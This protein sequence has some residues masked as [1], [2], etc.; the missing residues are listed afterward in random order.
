MRRILDRKNVRKIIYILFAAIL[1]AWGLQHIPYFYGMLMSLLKPMVPLIIGG[2]LAFILNIPMRFLEEKVITIKKEKR[3]R[4][5]SF[6]LT[7]LLVF[8]IFGLILF[9]VIPEL[10]RTFENIATMIPAFIKEATGWFDGFMTRFPMFADYIN[11]IDMSFDELGN[12]LLDLIKNSGDDVADFT[13]RLLSSLFGGALNVFLGFIF[14][15]YILFDKENLGRQVRRLLYAYLPEK[16][17]DQFIGVLGIINRIFHSFVTGQLTEAVILGSMFV[18]TM[19]IF[20][21]P[22]AVLV[23]ILVAVTAIIPVVG[24]FIAMFIGGFLIFVVNPM[25]AVW[26]VLLFLVLQQIEGNLIY[27]K[28]VGSSIGLPGIWVLAAV[29]VGGGLYGVLGVL[30]AVP[31]SSVVYTLLKR[32]VAHQ[33]KDEKPVDKR[34]YQ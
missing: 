23:G 1:F 24:A 3:R 25:Q 21:F 6:L 28:V 12:S 10:A 30:L 14:A 7:I 5:V 29:M 22:Y 2:A 16:K 19:F 32:D 33:L 11:G 27:P 18:V 34:K 26:F 20:G 17:V 13:V 4:G 9:L 8:F 31:I 15:T